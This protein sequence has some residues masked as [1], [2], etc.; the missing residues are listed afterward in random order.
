VAF[1]LTRVALP[2]LLVLVPTGLAMAAYNRAVTG[3]PLRMPYAV[4]EQTYAANPMFVWQT[5]GP[6]PEHRH[7]VMALFHAGWVR[8]LF[9][10][11]RISEGFARWAG[12]VLEGLVLFYLGPWL[13]LVLLALVHPRPAPWVGLAG[14]G[15]LLLVLGLVQVFCFAPHYAAP[16]VPLLAVL[17]VAGL[18]RVGAFRWRGWRLGQAFVG[19]LCLGYPLVLVLSALADPGTPADATHMVRAALA[20]QLQHEGG[21]HLIVV[22][23]ASAR[24]NGLGHEEW[25]FNG[26]DLDGAPVVWARA[27]GPDEDRRLL[28]YFADR[29]AWLLEVWAV[30]G[31]YRLTPHPLRPGAETAHCQ[32]GRGDSHA[33]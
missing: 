26:A 20:R 25:V 10:A 22:R 1:V 2:V 32:P 16:A 18:R 14:A 23:Y 24:P 5:P 33:R 3:D 7:R 15:C 11:H 6:V 13:L 4:H 17:V 12:D 31:E 19:S 8:D 21:K 29:N 28:D 30:E 9:L 27:I